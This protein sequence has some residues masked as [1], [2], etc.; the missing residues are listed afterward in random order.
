M[1]D[2]AVNNRG[3]RAGG[4]SLTACMR[5]G[6]AAKMVGTSRGK[7]VRP[8]TAQRTR[9]FGPTLVIA[10]Q[11]QSDHVRGTHMAVAAMQ[12]W[13]PIHSFTAISRCWA[14]IH[15]GASRQSVPVRQARRGR[16]TSR[17]DGAICSWPAPPSKHILDAK[18][19]MR[20]SVPPPHRREAHLV[21]TPPSDTQGEN[22]IDPVAWRSYAPT[23]FDWP[24]QSAVASFCCGPTRSTSTSNPHPT[25][26]PPSAPIESRDMP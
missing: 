21:N 2:A 25:S 1:Q 20:R 23:T 17:T 24:S 18:P 6:G 9:R 14:A 3:N 7:L 13:R 15:T 5:V 10:R 16:P 26:V 4:A 19:A 11:N 12:R 8:Q 22:V